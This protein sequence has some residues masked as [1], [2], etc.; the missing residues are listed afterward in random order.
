MKRLVVSLFAL[1]LLVVFITPAMA[2]VKIGGIIFTDFY[3]LNRDKENARD[4]GLGNGT[5]SYN[6][7]TIQLPNISRL[8][9]RW[10]N[11]D[12]VGMYIELGIGQ[13]YGSI[14]GWSD[15]VELRH[16][17]G[18]WNINDKLQLMAGK[19]TTPFS[20]LNPT[21]LLGTR[22]RS[23]NV[24][25]AGYGDLYPSRVPQ[26]R[27]TYKFND[28]IRIALAL[29]DPNS[30]ADVV[31]E[32]G[33]WY[34][35]AETSTKIPRIDIAV[36]MNFS[37]INIYPSFL[38]QRRTVDIVEYNEEY[39]KYGFPNDDAMTTYIASLGF[40]TGFGPLSFSAEGN[41]GKN[42]G[43]TA[44]FMGFSY[45]AIFSSA[46]FEN[47]NIHDAESYSFWGD[48][49]YKIGQFTPHLVY[50]EMTTKNRFWDTSFET[51]AKM[52]GVSCPIQ[53][54]NGFIIRPEIMFYDDGTIKIRG[55]QESED[56]LAGKYY[57]AGA[58][59]QITF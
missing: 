15:G 45:P 12:N 30:V 6:V 59:F 19:S 10:T 13:S 22:S 17:Y 50:G 55:D 5:T 54:A 29:V 48:L 34:W 44:G 38:W 3:Y 23:Y 36:P 11:E 46:G 18:W 2:D 33:P 25:G 27:A 52:Y 53:I 41:W 32:R 4:W 16:A 56:Y 39:Q 8:H 42:W 43:N 7:T 35:N 28:Q 26:I 20:Q 37:W 14:G 57:I 51:K 58:Q 40:K 9:V 24:I 47:G 1:L 31:G 21:Q 49:S